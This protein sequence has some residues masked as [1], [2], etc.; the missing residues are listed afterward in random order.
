[1]LESFKALFSKS[2]SIAMEQMVSLLPKV[3]AGIL[4]LFLGYAIARIVRGLAAQFFLAIRL[5]RF[6]QRLGLSGFLARGDVRYTIAEILA[7][8]IYWLVLILSL[9]IL[10]ATFG[11]HSVTAFF[12]AILVYIPRIAVALAI[13]VAGI[14]VGS[15]FGSAVQV[16]GSNA[17]FSG[18]A[19]AGVGVSYLIGFFA[20]VMAL[21]HL[22]LATQ[23]LVTTLQ[24]V[25]A[26]V[27]LALALAFGLGCK[28]LAA[29]TVKAWFKEAEA[30]QAKKGTVEQNEAKQ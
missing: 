4:I 13:L 12:G 2:Y 7:T 26:A 15:F 11:L 9:D 17:R 5:D 3:L 24:I 10:G 14:V 20:L 22:Q 1:M 21:E 6:A 29:Q 18:A 23:L 30:Q 16:A 27:A 25:I 8:S 28:D 19:A